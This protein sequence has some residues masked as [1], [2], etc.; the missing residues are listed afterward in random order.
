MTTIAIRGWK[1]RGTVESLTLQ[2]PP[3]KEPPH[4]GPGKG[5]LGAFITSIVVSRE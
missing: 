1:Y 2:S 3:G 5:S 4:T